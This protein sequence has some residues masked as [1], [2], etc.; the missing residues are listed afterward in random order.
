[1]AH[2]IAMVI[3]AA[4]VTLLIYASYLW[5]ER[6]RLEG[7][8]DEIERYVARQQNFKGSRGDP[9]WDGALYFVRRKIRRVRH[10]ETTCL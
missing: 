3:L 2:K 6:E 4:F 7:Q 5:D 9:G 1:M 10:G 8:L